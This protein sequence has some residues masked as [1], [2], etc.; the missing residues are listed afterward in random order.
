MTRTAL[1]TLAAAATVALTACSDTAPESAPPSPAAPASRP[2][3]SEPATPS[4]KPTAPPTDDPTTKSGPKLVAADV[5]NLERTAI[6]IGKPV[7]LTTALDGGDPYILSSRPDGSVGL[8]RTK[9]SESGRMLLKPAKVRKQT[10]ENQNTVVVVAAPS[11]E[12]SGPD[13]CVTDVSRGELRMQEC[14]DGAKNQAWKLT[15]EGDFGL[16]VLTGDHTVLRSESGKITQEGWP[17]YTAEL[18]G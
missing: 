5:S 6:I 11:V 7:E 1:L 15:Q 4:S 16:F 8:E 13:R 12:G 9:L 14:E 17:L 2:A 3:A 18:E 10:E